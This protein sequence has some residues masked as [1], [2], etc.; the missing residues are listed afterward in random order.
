MTVNWH[1]VFP[2]ATTQ[3]RPVQSLDLAA[4]ATHVEWLIGERI[5]G[6]IMLGTVGEN[7][8]LEPHEKLDVLWAAVKQVAGRVPVLSGVAECSTALAC[9]FAAE[10]KK[11][12]V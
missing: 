7:C 6:V 1:G 10:A 5:H 9:R 2:A 11:L 4:T 12:G 8:A 3:F